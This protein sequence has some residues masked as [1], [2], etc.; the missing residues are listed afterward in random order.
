MFIPG[1]TVALYVMAAALAV[2]VGRDLVK[3]LLKE[4][5]KLIAL[6]KNAIALAQKLQGFGMTIIPNM[7]TEFGTGDVVG[8]AE[9]IEKQVVLFLD[10][11]NG[12]AAVLQ[13]LE[14]TF[15]NVL[16]AKL[17]TPA[18]LALVQAQIAALSAPA[19]SK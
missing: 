1:T 10:P 15:E 4:D 7:L 9:E 13:E 14:Q 16:K 3:W 6:R 8:L 2:L 12:D 19:A 11:K 18:G 5:A 17:A